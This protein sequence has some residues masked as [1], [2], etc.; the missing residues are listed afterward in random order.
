[1]EKWR[2]VVDFL[3][4]PTGGPPVVG[5]AL[6]LNLAIVFVCL[7]QVVLPLEEGHG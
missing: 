6:H 3:L 4:G 2:Q 1:M 7:K 5:D